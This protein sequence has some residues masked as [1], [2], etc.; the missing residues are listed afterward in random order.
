[1]KRF[2]LIIVCGLVSGCAYSPVV[3]LRASEEE[4]Y[5]YQRDLMECRELA[6]DVDLSIFSKNHRAV[7]RCLRGRGHSIID[8]VGGHP[9]TLMSFMINQR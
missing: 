1:M 9:S 3:D 2:L 7:A 5:L 8:D 6:K 4:A